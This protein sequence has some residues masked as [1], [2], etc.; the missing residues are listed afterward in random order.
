MPAPHID[1]A[2]VSLPP[3]NS[4]YLTARPAPERNEEPPPLE[5]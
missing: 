2:A 1:P 3:T 4:V 5:G